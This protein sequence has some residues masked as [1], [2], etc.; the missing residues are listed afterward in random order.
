MQHEHIENGVYKITLESEVPDVYT[1]LA[2]LTNQETNIPL[3]HNI[4]DA[5][6]TE[7][8]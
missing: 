7:Q 1:F 5:T 2:Y 8:T 4:L 6:F 3:S